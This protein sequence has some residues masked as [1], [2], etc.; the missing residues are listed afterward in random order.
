MLLDYN[1]TLKI[2]DFAGSLV[3]GC[4]LPP[5]VD[6]EVES[7]LPG[8]VEPSIRTDLF[9]LG[10]AIYEMITKRPPY[11]GKSYAEIQRS[12]MSDRFPQDFENFEDLR[13][14]VEQCWGKGGRYYASADEVLSDLHKLGPWPSH[15][16]VRPER[17]ELYAGPT[18]HTSHRA[19]SPPQLPQKPDMDT[20]APQYV[21]SSKN[22]KR[23]R[24]HRKTQYYCAASNHTR[25]RHRKE[26]YSENSFDRLVTSFHSLLLW[27]GHTRTSRQKKYYI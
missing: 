20:V 21:S 5:S 2:A 9:A 11:K 12:F 27:P 10:S 6:Y 7:K 8:E 23:T 18:K 24:K 13:P 4:D 22:K 14:I 19:S 15:I 25:T 17:K 16:N 1:G 26:N 3:K